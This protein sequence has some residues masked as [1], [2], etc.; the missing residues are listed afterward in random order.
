[1]AGALSMRRPFF[2]WGA[3]SATAKGSYNLDCQSAA[4][5]LTASCSA[6]VKYGMNFFPFVRFTVL[7]WIAFALFLLSLAVA[8]TDQDGI[9][10]IAAALREEQYEPA[11][12]ML[13]NAL[14]QNPRNAELWTMQGVAYN[15]LG[16]EEEALGAFRHALQLSPDAIPAL[17]GAAKIEYDKGDAAGIPILERL[18]RLRPSDLTSHGMLAVLEYQR[19][20]C[21][22]AVVHFERAASLFE[23]QAPALNAYG[24][25][26]VKLR[27]FDR[28]ADVFQKSLALHPEDRRE[29]EVLAS[30]QLMAHQPQQAIATLDP[31]LSATPDSATL[32]LAS[33]AFEDRHDTDKA[34]DALR[35]AILLEPQDVSLYVDFAA[36]SAAHQ[37]FQIGINVVNDG[38]A[39]QPKAAPL[40]LARG[41][42][43]VE[44]AEYE[45]A[46]DDFDT[47]YK[48]DPKQSLT[49]AAQDMTA[50]Q[51]N[52][53]T[54]ALAGVQAK[55]AKR[56]NDPI[57]LYL[58]ADVLALQ[59]P[60]PGSAEFQNALRSAKK[61]TSLDPSLAPARTVLAKLYLEAGQ[62]SE[63][64]DECRKAL[65]VNPD[66]QTALYLLIRSLGKTEQRSEVPDLLK[67]LALARQKAANKKR[68]EN[69]F[70]LVE[71]EPEPK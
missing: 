54:G 28:A 3:E 38:I 7:L 66:D 51:Q 48:L 55:L 64:A 37:S 57:L 62:H 71:G 70:K 59:D 49:A 14:R 56:P 21:D 5:G 50:I 42:L 6:L 41:M 36:L 60:K 22:A 19:G 45:K 43:Y 68:E 17:Q 40:Y 11:L 32:E 53:L 10:R 16:S 13:R 26:L 12:Q 44:L 34:V 30:V 8:Q 39:V 61:A 67:R 31:L 20:H 25:C 29:R 46:Q 69:R 24:T 35:Q 1:M 65:E 4:H 58:Q 47:A 63:A 15:G 27:Q 9:Q 52:D 2:S 18:L 33:A 23:A